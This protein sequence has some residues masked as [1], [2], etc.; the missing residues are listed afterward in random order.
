[1]TCC[2]KCGCGVLTRTNGR[3]ENV[4]LSVDVQPLAEPSATAQGRASLERSLSRRADRPADVER[5]RHGK[6]K[7][8]CAAPSTICRPLQ[9]DLPPQ[10]RGRPFY[11]AIAST[12]GISIKTVETQMGRALKALRSALSRPPLIRG[13]KRRV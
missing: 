9:G 6:W 2:S 13:A 11:N 10:P 4:S 3:V 7:Q 12:L 5:R 8:P 1:M